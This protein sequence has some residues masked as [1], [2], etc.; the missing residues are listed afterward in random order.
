MKK[1]KNISGGGAG[2]P[3]WLWGPLGPPN[4][5]EVIIEHGL[6]EVAPVFLNI[7]AN[8]D[9]LGITYL[10]EEVKQ[11]YLLKKQ[12]EEEKRQAEAKRKEEEMKKMRAQ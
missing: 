2:P 3:Q 5:Q 7:P 9:E 4:D 12:E 6:E 11:A 10:P 8:E 1:H